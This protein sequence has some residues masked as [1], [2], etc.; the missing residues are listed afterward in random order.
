MLIVFTT[1]LT[2]YDDSKLTDSLPVASS[3]KICFSSIDY[4]KN[5]V[6]ETNVSPEDG[7][8]SLNSLFIPLNKYYWT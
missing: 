6:S 2:V 5:L 8:H 1:S 3:I 7:S 4:M